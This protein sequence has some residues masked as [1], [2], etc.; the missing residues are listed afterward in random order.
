MLSPRHKVRRG[1]R[2]R[3]KQGAKLTMAS[4]MR[5]LAHRYLLAPTPNRA[6]VETHQ[7]LT[8][9]IRAHLDQAPHYDRAQAYDHHL[10]Q[11]TGR[12]P[13]RS[14]YCGGISSMHLRYGTMIVSWRWSNATM[15]SS[16]WKH[17]IQPYQFDRDGKSRAARERHASRLA[18]SWH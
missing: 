11:Q 3:R 1:A 10:T 14:K 2:G 18:V 15:L 12:L 4:L 7:L 8:H 16:C 5:P 17:I 9:L 13:L 6:N